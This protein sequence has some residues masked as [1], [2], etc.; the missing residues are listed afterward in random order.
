[1]RP[2]PAPRLGD[3]HGLLRAINARE[4]LRVDEFVTEFTI[5]ELF[6]PGLENALGRTRQFISFARSAGLLAEDRGTVELTPMGKRY[7]RAGDPAQPFEV[8][9]AQAEWLRRLLR[10]RHMTDSIYHGAAVALSLL[11]SSPP[12]FHVST[13]D[14]GRAISDLGRAGWDNE[15]TFLSQGERFA[16]F[17][18]DMELIDADRRLTPAGRETLDELTLPIHRSVKDIAGQLNP[19]GL[20]AAIREGDAEWAPPLPP[21]PPAAAAVPE[22]PAPTLAPEP[23]PAATPAPLPPEPA[24]P[25]MAPAPPPP[26]EPPPPPRIVTAPPM[27]QPVAADE[28]DEVPEWSTVMAA[29]VPPPEAPV[30]PSAE[31]ET[32]PAPVAGPAAVLDVPT[33]RAAAQESGLRLPDRLYAAVAAALAGGSHLLL[34]G[35]PGAGKTT[36]A[37]A[38]AKA[39]VRS[40]KAEGATVVTASR[41]WSAADT[42]GRQ[43]DGAWQPGTVVGAAS[44]ARWL[45]VDELDRADLDGSLGDLSTFL[46]GVPVALPDGEAAP[47]EGWR[48]IATAGR[49]GLQGSPELLR[50]FAHVKV[51]PPAADQMDAAIDEAAGG[52]AVAAGAAK[53]LLGAREIG[54]VGTGAFLDAARFAAA[55]NA[56]AP[57]DERRLAREAL[58]AHI[59]PLMG[60]LDD[61]GRARMAALAG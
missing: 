30:A 8:S 24:A 4:R 12:D 58:A 49:K 3:T 1:M 48:I 18:T 57:T 35:P 16:T 29:A 21:E 43:D 5:E 51:P 26:P 25:V 9:A 22:E 53:R 32:P 2:I 46:A 28:D 37:L 52:D 59:E 33:L 31:E 27:P 42:V 7:T 50:R 60:L 41:G 55:C 11:A 38:I 15:N 14:L 19:G 23:P 45:I 54:P 36:L 56:L 47:P 39:A 40:G 6:P 13:L 17:V 34:T 20:E 61:D 44:Q 10:E